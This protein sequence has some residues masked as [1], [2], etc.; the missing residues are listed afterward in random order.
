MYSISPYS[1]IIHAAHNQWAQLLVD[2]HLATIASAC[3]ESRYV[4]SGLVHANGSVTLVAQRLSPLPE[5]AENVPAVEPGLFAAA[6]L[7]PI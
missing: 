2:G 6:G 4:L 7:L 3:A 5:A 1:I